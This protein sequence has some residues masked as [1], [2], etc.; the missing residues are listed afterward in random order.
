MT[1]HKIATREEWLELLDAEKEHAR[2]GDE[3]ARRL[4]ELLWVRIEQ[5]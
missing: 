2:C 1:E 3:L 4:R 5:P